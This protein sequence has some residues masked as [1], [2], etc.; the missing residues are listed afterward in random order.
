ME[1]QSS[2]LSL[3]AVLPKMIAMIDMGL[4]KPPI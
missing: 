1:G 4:P 3:L 2:E